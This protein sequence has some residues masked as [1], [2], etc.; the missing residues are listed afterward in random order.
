MLYLHTIMKWVSK[1]VKLYAVINTFTSR[2]VQ[3][4]R[5]FDKFSDQLKVLIV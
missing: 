5:K 4:A 3:E 2:K 1:T